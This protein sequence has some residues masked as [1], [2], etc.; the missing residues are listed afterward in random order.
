MNILIVLYLIKKEIKIK[1]IKVYKG[2]YLCLVYSVLNLIILNC[3]NSSKKS[4]NIIS[5]IKQNNAPNFQ[6]CND[7]LHALPRQEAIQR[8]Y[9][10]QLL[11]QNELHKSKFGF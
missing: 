6:V 11:L 8:I 2:I 9:V 3:L 10:F 1:I 7:S 5:S 4:T